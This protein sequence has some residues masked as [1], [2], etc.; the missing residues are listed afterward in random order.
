MGE[1]LQLSDD[2]V[3]NGGDY[4]GLLLQGGPA[5]GF[6]QGRRAGGPPHQ[7]AFHSPLRSVDWLPSVSVS[8][9]VSGDCED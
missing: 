2:V 7:E 6:G 1:A 4:R 5:G 9:S 3:L 8:V